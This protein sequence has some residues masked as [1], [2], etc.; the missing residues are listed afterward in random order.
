MVFARLTSGQERASTTGEG[1]EAQRAPCIKINLLVY[2]EP[3]MLSAETSG[4]S[5]SAPTDS[6]QW[7]KFR[8]FV[9]LICS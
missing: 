2:F 4:Q 1:S 3:E 7:C 5:Q 6:A 8:C 9:L